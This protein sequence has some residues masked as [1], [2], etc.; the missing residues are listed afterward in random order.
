MTA[1][2]FSICV[3][4]LLV[5]AFTAD[6]IFLPVS[7]ADGIN[8]VG[9]KTE[10]CNFWDGKIE[11]SLS[12]YG[13]IGLCGAF[14][15]L[16]YDANALLFSSLTCLN[17]TRD[18]DISY[19]DCGGRLLIL[20]DGY[21]SCD[22]DTRLASVFFEL[23][24]SELECLEF[25]LKPIGDEY[26][27][28]RSKNGELLSVDAALDG[29][30]IGARGWY[31]SDESASSPE[32]VSISLSSERGNVLSAALKGEYPTGGFAPVGFKLFAI[33]MK[34]GVG[35]M[36]YASKCVPVGDTFELTVDVPLQFSA[37]GCL[38]LLL[39]PAIYTSKG[40]VLGEKYVFV[41]IDGNIIYEK[42]TVRTNSEPFSLINHITASIQ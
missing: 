8:V 14:F 41:V 23:K 40:A 31:E 39:S 16:D 5:F 33:D 19:R 2:L 15:E 35:E 9:I 26:A 37:D 36:I 22:V 7:A 20:V 10:L 6:A 1:K 27:F 24:S 13:D 4:L 42:K 17:L 18:L 38:V 12:V 21:E 28:Y 11:I 34:L 3:A 30:S 29:L 25:Q 32:L